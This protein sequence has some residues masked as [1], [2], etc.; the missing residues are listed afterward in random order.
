MALRLTPYGRREIA[1]ATA[2]G[3]LLCSLVALAAWGASW[4]LLVAAAA[5]LAAWLSVLWF[6]RDPD[7]QAPAG[8]GLFVSPADGR[9]ADITPVG[10]DSPLGRDGMRIGIFMDIFSVHVN[11]SPEAGRVEKIEHH[12]GVFLDARHPDAPQRNESAT[13]YVT[14]ARGGREFPFVVRQIAGFIAR[15]IVTDLAPAQ[16]LARGQRMGMI[17]FGSRLELFVPRELAGGVRVR[18]GDRVRAGLT[19]LIAAAKETDDDPIAA[20]R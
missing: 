16:R 5:P 2:L 6:F 11:R 19:V 10:P 20:D 7:R 18:V 14:G 8:D 13:I 17:K 3:I 1:L 12:D 15:R 9:V 4:W